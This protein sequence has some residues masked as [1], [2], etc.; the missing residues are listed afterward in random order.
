VWRGIKSEHEQVHLVLVGTGGLD[1]HN[2]E[3]ELKEY[4]RSHGLQDSVRFTGAVENV[5]EYLQAADI[6]VFPTEREAF[7]ISLIE[8]M[9][10]GLAVISTSAGGTKGLLKHG[11]D[12]LVV[13]AGSPQQL[14]DALHSLIT[15]EPLSMCLG[16]NAWRTARQRFAA[17]RVT[18]QYIDL[19][20]HTAFAPN[21]DAPTSD[22]YH[23]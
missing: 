15:N 6:F 21:S 11:Q 12:G 9:A 16:Q 2:C 8:A 20:E 19:F 18:Q 1:I 7:G 3:A 5:H 4:V 17:E 14:H 22:E 13:E 23:C 10:C